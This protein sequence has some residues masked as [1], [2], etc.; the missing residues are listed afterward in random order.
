[1]PGSIQPVQPSAPPRAS[2]QELPTMWKRGQAHFF[3]RVF[4][5][6][7]IPEIAQ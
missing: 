1:M 6:T 5:P 4:E 7:K 3:L 2:L